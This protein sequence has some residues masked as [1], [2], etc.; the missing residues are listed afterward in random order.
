MRQCVFTCIFAAFPAN[1][2]EI[3]VWSKCGRMQ[4]VLFGIF[5]VIFGDFGQ[6]LTWRGF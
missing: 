6:W 5:G 2:D 3:E 1:L 4:I